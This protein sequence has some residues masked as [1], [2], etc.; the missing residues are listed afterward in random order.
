MNPCAGELTSACAANEMRV[1]D[2]LGMRDPLRPGV[3]R[4][5]QL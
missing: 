2:D 3:V 4:G 1:P 5:E